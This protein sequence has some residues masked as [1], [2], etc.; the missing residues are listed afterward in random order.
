MNWASIS[1]Y[2]LKDRQL[3]EFLPITDIYNTND[4]FEDDE[5][6]PVFQYPT[7]TN[8]KKMTLLLLKGIFVLANY[9]AVI[10]YMT[11]VIDLNKGEC[12]IFKSTKQNL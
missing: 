9:P 6:Q 4:T 2:S 11:Q 7:K 1:H 12:W 8:V 5:V 10:V 3:S